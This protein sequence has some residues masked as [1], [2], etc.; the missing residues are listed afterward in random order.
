MM[1]KTNATANI[2]RQIDAQCSEM[3]LVLLLLDGAVRFA[4]EA[5][6]H[7]K[8]GHWAEKGRAVES[9]MECLHQLR[10]GLNRDNRTEIVDTLDHTYDFL[11]TK[12]AMGNA[13]RDA[14]QLEQ[15]V[16]SLESLRAGWVELFERLKAQGRL[17]PVREDSLAAQ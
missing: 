6:D 9:A 7:M 10:C 14:A 2:Y 11:S 13:A 3:Q 12:L 17:S 15:V 4:R 1:M 16:S 5:A 8:A